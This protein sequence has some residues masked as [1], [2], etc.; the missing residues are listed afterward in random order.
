MPTASVV[1]SRPD[2]SDEDTR[3]CKPF[4]DGSDGQHR[5]TCLVWCQHAPGTT[6]RSRPG[7]LPLPHI[8]PS[9]RQLRSFQECACL[10]GS[11][12]S[13]DHLQGRLHLLLSMHRKPAHGA[14]ASVLRHSAV[15]TAQLAH[16]YMTT[17]KTIAL[18]RR[19]LVRKVI[20]VSAFAYAL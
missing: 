19:T 16:P 6:R 18:T 9:G 14:K 5:V 20:N 8:T 4:A 2:L 10:A 15:F 11:A 17:G 1:E 13:C 12:M 3:Q 7:S